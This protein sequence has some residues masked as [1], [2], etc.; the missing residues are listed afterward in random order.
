MH[1]VVPI[2]CASLGDDYIVRRY[3]HANRTTLLKSLS[4][5]LQIGIQVNSWSKRREYTESASVGFMIPSVEAL[6]DRYEV[7]FMLEKGFKK[8][9]PSGWLTFAKAV[10]DSK[11]EIETIRL[12]DMV[13]TA[14]LD[15][16]DEVSD[17]AATY[18]EKLKKH[19]REANPLEEF[20]LP[21]S[22]FLINRTLALRYLEGSYSSDGVEPLIKKVHAGRSYGESEF[23][24]STWIE[25]Q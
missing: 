6:I 25:K 10:H 4:V 24:F 8:P 21:A 16:L 9:R 7:S 17:N 23:W 13:R 12:A 22:T 14:L 20:Y 1:K 11:E 2:L 5:D 19:L 15:L 18:G 3:P